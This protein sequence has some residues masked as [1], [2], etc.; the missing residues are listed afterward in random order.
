MSLGIRAMSANYAALQT[1]GQNIA[2]ANVPGYSRQSVVLETSKGQF[3]GAG[4]LGKG[5]EVASVTRSYNQ[6]LA[7]ETAD[8]KSLA[9]MDQARLLSLQRLEQ[10]FQPGENGLGYAATEVFNA[11]VDLSSR[12][13]DLATRQVVLARANDMAMRFAEAGSALDQTQAST[14]ADLKSSVA[15]VNQ[16]TAA[17]AKANDQVAALR[18]AGHPANDVLDERDRLITR[19]S[20]RVL[21]TR[22]EAEDGSVGL[23]IGG[24]QRLVLGGEATEMRVVASDLDPSRSALAMREGAINRAIDNKTLGGGSLSGLLRFQNQDLVAGRVL[25]GQMA[26]A[27]GMALNDQQVRGLNLQAPAGTVPSQPLFSL[28]PQVAL[29]QAGN[30][31]DFA[32]LPIGSVTLTVT[33]SRALQASEYDLRE[34]AGSP[35]S[36]QLTRLSDGLVSTVNSGDVVDGLRIDVNNPQAGDRFLLQPVSRAANGMRALLTSP[37]DLAAA[38]PLLVTPLNANTGTAVA[39]DMVVTASPLPFAGA[40]E[41]LS[42]SRVGNDYVYT[43]SLTGISTP[44]RTGE[45]VI[46]GNGYTLQISGVPGDGDSFVVAPTPASALATNNG[47]AR[48]LLGLRDA[49]IAGGRTVSDTWSQSMADMG[50]RVQSAVSSVSISAAVAKQAEQTRSG[51]DGV[52][53]DEEAARLIQYQQSYQAAAKVLQVAQSLFDTLLQTAGR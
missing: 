3:T 45:P 22:V 9:A 4:F 26:A 44:W 10:V 38:A 13:A 34:S 2:N 21:V 41:T 16:L 24:G 17:I 15:E 42:F 46:G 36:W 20:E 53:L 25:I 43:S 29:P 39:A 50:V 23:F 49:A 8:A 7:R 6:F 32:G 37:L 30:L 5:V 31:K 18:G 28:G 51:Q 19:L 35:G 47:N 48:A 40:T 27:V 52:N 12:P 14:T 11:M 33:D 1:T